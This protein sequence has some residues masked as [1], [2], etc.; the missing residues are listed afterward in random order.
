MINGPFKATKRLK[1]NPTLKLEIT[2]KSSD[3]RLFYVET[4]QTKTKLVLQRTLDGFDLR[5]FD[6]RGQIAGRV[7]NNWEVNQYAE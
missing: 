5:K 7:Y 1:L 2:G 4:A 3:G 6:I